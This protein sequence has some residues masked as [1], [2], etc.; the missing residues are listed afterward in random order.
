MGV[1]GSTRWSVQASRWVVEAPGA[2]ARTERA[3]Y[4]PRR[5]ET[6]VVMVPA[7]PGRDVLPENIPLA[8]VFEDEHLLVIDKAAGMVV[9][10]APGNWSGNAW[11]AAARAPGAW[12]TRCCSRR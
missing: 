7:A 11:R 3:S 5:G 2:N 12:T 1:P 6:I 8:V 4:K 10:P 9:H